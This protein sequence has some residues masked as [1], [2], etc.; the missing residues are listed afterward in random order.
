M[1]GPSEVDLRRAVP[2]EVVEVDGSRGAVAGAQLDAH[3][4]DGLTAGVL[5][6]PLEVVLRAGLEQSA[7]A[8]SPDERIA[9][10]V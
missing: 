8:R 3:R 1:R 5:D 4:S 7:R 10:V 2:G 6:S 9:A